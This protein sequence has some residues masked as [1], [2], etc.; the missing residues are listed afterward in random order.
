MTQERLADAARTSQK[1]I[2]QI[3]RTSAR[4]G[5]EALRALADALEMPLEMLTMRARV[6]ENDRAR[7]ERSSD[8]R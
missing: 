5:Y 7:A 8:G 3:E 4:V 1:R 6:I 2:W